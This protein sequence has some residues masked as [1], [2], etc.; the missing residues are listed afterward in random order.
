MQHGQ[1]YLQLITVPDID[2]PKELYLQLLLCFAYLF[3]CLQQIEAL[4]RDKR[5]RWHNDNFWGSCVVYIHMLIARLT[6]IS[7]TLPLCIDCIYF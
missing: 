2:H 3:I 1:S 4:G 5:L 6:E 7:L